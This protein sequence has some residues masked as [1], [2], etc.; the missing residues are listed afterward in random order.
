MMPDEK[1]PSSPETF[2]PLQIV[3]K[4]P[5]G[6]SSVSQ[7]VEATWEDDETRATSILR[8]LFVL[9]SGGLLLWAQWRA[10]VDWTGPIAQNWSRWVLTSLVFNFVLPLGIVHLFFGQV[11]VYQDWLKEQK[12]NGWTYGWKWD[13]W[14]KHLLYALVMW[15]AML[16]FLIYFS[17]QFAIRADYARYLPVTNTPFDWLFLIGSL[18]LYML[19]WEWYFRGFGLFGLAQGFGPLVAITIQALAFGLAHAGKPPVEMVGAFAGGAI[20]GALC[21][22]EKS[23]VPAFF[24]HTLI[25]VTWAIL[26]KI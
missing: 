4:S 3:D 6:E 12:H 8:S 21:W 13:N 23:F 16:P 26:V 25:H 9:V 17:R 11:L 22:R 20:L 7:A 14:K 19:C 10:P 24:T 15:G 2:P 18:V 5:L 1:T